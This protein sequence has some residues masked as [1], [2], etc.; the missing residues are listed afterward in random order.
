[1]SRLNPVDDSY[2]YTDQIARRTYQAK[3]PPTGL[4][5]R[6]RLKRAEAWAQAPPFFSVPFLTCNSTGFRQCDSVQ[7]ASLG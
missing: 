5:A 3:R 2:A 4:V 7:R 6:A 1:M